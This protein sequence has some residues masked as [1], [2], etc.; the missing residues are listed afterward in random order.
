MLPDSGKQVFGRLFLLKAGNVGVFLFFI[1][2]PFYQLAMLYNF[3][4]LHLLSPSLRSLCLKWFP[5]GLLQKVIL[6]KSDLVF[7]QIQN[8]FQQLQ[9]TQMGETQQKVER[10][11]VNE[12][13]KRHIEFEGIQLIWSV[14][15][16]IVL[17][18][19]IG[20]EKRRISLLSITLKQKFL[21][22][23][24]CHKCVLCY[25]EAMQFCKI[26]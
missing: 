11:Y 24:L 22:R 18:A 10:I 20:E 14:L 5:T 7:I 3:F 26:W 25:S 17:A 16:D 23:H 21:S 8:G 12:E 13:T 19:E 9:C 6:H 1:N 2:C 4:W 15:R